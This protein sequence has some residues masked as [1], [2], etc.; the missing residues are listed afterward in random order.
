M[1]QA[2]QNLVPQ[3]WSGTFEL[4]AT[5]IS[6][7]PAWHTA[8][9]NFAWYGTS[10][11]EVLLKRV[12]VLLPMLLLIAAIWSTMVSLYT[13]P[14]R[15][16][17][18]GFLTSMFAAWWDAGRTIWFYWAGM[19][20]VGI[21]LV[22]WIKGL[23]RLT[24]ALLKS[25]FQSPLNFLDWTSRSYFKPGVP[26][27][28]FLGLLVWSVVEAL[29]FTY[30][31]RP[32][33]TEVLAGITGFEPNAAL[34]TPILWFFLFFLILGSFACIQVLGDAMQKRQVGQ[35]LQ[36]VL[37]ELSV[38]FFE[39]MFLYREMIDALTPWIAQQTNE[40]LQLG[41]WATLSLAA[42][43]WVG[44]R[45][46]TWF[47]FGRFGTPALLAILGR[48]TVK[49]DGPMIAREVSVDAMKG[50][51]AALKAETEWFR[52]EAR[53]VFELLSLPVLQL[54]AAAV[55]FAVVTVTSR[56]MFS[57]P[58]ASLDEVLAASPRSGGSKKAKAAKVD[59]PIQFHG[60]AAQ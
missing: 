5:P 7:I 60:G 31:L 12:L 15:S 47:L 36:M 56:P 38:I 59:A 53:K 28:A 54:L 19:V 35:I 10:A 22:G 39:V 6:W 21:V 24:L 43:G 1:L 17:R 50:P 41:L 37:V 3:E 48:E 44:V 20:R 57:L 49:Q 11:P 8:M 40:R 14:F 46:M 23:V 52:A 9:I 4:L 30:T 34:M 13:L 45:G 33:M 26:W 27:V 55:N 51:I 29:I 16:A 42:F 2:T 58:F 32:T 18:G 25:A